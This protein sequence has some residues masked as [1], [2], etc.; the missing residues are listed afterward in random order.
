MRAKL[1]R[2]AFN[3]KGNAP[4]TDYGAL[5]LPQW[6]VCIRVE[7]VL[8]LKRRK[9]RFGTFVVSVARFGAT[10]GAFETDAASVADQLSEIVEDARR[11]RALDDALLP[12]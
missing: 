2:V 7:R 6:V 5:F 4:V 9:P 8:E 12:A 1:E 3:L 10:T 11:H